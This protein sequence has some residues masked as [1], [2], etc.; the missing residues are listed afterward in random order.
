MRAPISWLR[1]FVELPADVSGRDLA[2]A[3]IA[4]GLEVETVD[5]VADVA[6]PVVVG[7]VNEIE[8]LSE[9][10]KPIRFCQVDVGEANGGV[11]GIVCGATNFEVGDLVVVALPGAV[12][13]GGFEISARQT[14][15]RTSDGPRRNCSASAKKSSTS[16]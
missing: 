12:L 14:Y 15:G 3:L 2:A 8:L 11:R 9:F 5:V 1:E 6:G 13:P 4:L 10:K 16:P 7:R